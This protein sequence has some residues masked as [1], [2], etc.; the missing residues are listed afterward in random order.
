MGQDIKKHLKESLHSEDLNPRAVAG[1][2]RIILRHYRTSGRRLPWRETGD[3]YEILVSEFML[4]QTQVERVIGKY[5]AF[6]EAFPDFEALADAHLREILA[7]WQG[8]GYNRRAMALHRTARQVIGEFD[9]QL[10]DSTELLMTLPGVGQA[11][12][13]ALSAF[14][15]NKPV[16]FIETNI[17][18]VFI[19]FFFPDRD[20]IRDQEILPL[21]DKTLD[22]DSVRDWYYGLMDYGSML[23]KVSGNPNRRSAHHH[24]QGAFENS[25]RQIRGAILRALLTH[26]TISMANLVKILGKSDNRIMRLADQLAQEGF[27]ERNGTMLCISDGSQTG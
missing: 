6:L 26:G 16:V 10:P 14:A 8:L 23:K 7:V 3:P 27:L 15:Y 20:G 4:Q 22:R 17:R 12:A 2:Q 13:G 19:H 25:D 9:G 1:F 18:R 11:T 21:V 24:V 5:G